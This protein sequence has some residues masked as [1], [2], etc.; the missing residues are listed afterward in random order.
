MEGER[1]AGRAPGRQW[2]PRHRH[3]RLDRRGGD[4]RRPRGVRADGRRARGGRRGRAARLRHRHQRHPP[5]GGADQGSGRARRRRG[6][7]RHA[8]LQQAQP[9]RDRGSLRSDRRRPASC[10]SSP[11]TSPR[12]WW[13]TCRPSCSP[14][15]PGSTTW[16]PS[17]KRTTR[18]CSRSTGLAIL[19]GN[20]DIF[21]KTLELGGAGGI[22]VASHLVG[23]QMREIWEAVQA[24]DLE[25]ARKI[26]AAC[27]SSTTRSA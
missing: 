22:L 20:D 14:S 27:A 16:S 1:H 2:L 25:R 3:L 18:S 7:G 23:A 24:G 5:L 21:L 11:T 6:A 19:A 13:S 26:D 4:D 15:W 12:G 10:R 8:L 9:G 17:S